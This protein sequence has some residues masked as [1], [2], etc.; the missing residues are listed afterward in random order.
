MV[1]ALLV[2]KWP[3]EL[4]YHHKSCIRQ[5]A[6]LLPEQAA[7][8]SKANQVAFLEQ[9]ALEGEPIEASFL[10]AALPV[11]GESVTLCP[12][13]LLNLMCTCAGLQRQC[14]SVLSCLALLRPSLMH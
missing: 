14:V 5:V 1:Q 3:V 8:V 9:A 12:A 2:A 11:V 6:Q 13:P 4:Q 10:E 7:A